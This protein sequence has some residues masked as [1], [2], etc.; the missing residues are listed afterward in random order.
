MEKELYV[1]LGD[2]VDSRKL[3]QRE[4]FQKRLNHACTEINQRYKR[5]LYADMKIIKGA[6]EIRCVLKTV[7][8]VYNIMDFVW[9][10]IY[11]QK[12]RFVLVRGLIDTSLSNRD[13][14]QMDGP[15]FHHASNMMNSLKK[16]GLFFEMSL[17]NDVTD[18]ALKGQVNLIIII[19]NSW[20]S[21]RRE[22]VRM[23]EKEGSQK[24]VADKMGISQQAVSKNLKESMWNKVK[25]IEKDLKKSMNSYSRLDK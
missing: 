16:S 11:P 2:V 6:D 21:R 22:I 8:N 5:D 13:I 23:Y 3:N 10:E 1:L 4:Y 9:N 25:L 24:D 18:A 14:T 15:A 12:M 20:S 17:G 7:E 19:K